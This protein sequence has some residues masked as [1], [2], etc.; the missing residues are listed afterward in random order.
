MRA[1]TSLFLPPEVEIVVGVFATKHQQAATGLHPGCDAVNVSLP[2]RLH[3]VEGEQQNT[4]RLQIVRLAGT[5]ELGHLDRNALHKQG[6]R[7]A[8]ERIEIGQRGPSVP[9]SGVTA[10]WFCISPRAFTTV[11]MAVANSGGTCPKMRVGQG[12]TS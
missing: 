12:M 7:Q 9:W 3:G 8:V 4:I 5:V 2:G 10:R 6:Q 1:G 11:Q